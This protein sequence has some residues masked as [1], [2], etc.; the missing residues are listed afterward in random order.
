MKPTKPK[1]STKTTSAKKTPSTS[2][3]TPKRAKKTAAKHTPKTARPTRLADV[4]AAPKGA[5][6]P[7]SAVKPGER[8]RGVKRGLATDYVV[9]K[10]GPGADP[11]VAF[12]IPDRHHTPTTRTTVTTI[13]WSLFLRDYKARRLELTEAT[14]KSLA[15]TPAQKAALTD[16]H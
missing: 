10:V 6:I 15:L 7:A 9:A 2:T 5:V 1:K 13:R 12:Y 4:P 8:Y 11:I 14:V 3:A 16:R